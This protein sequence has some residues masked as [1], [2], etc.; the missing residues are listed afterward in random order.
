MKVL[1]TGAAGF[2]GSHLVPE[3]VLAGHEVRAMVR[4]TS[5]D[6]GHG[7]EVVRADLLDK[8]SLGGALEGIEV[9][10][11]LVHSMTTSKEFEDTDRRAAHI[12]AAAARRHGVRRIIYLGGLGDDDDLSPHLASRSEV[13]QILGS[14]GIPVTTLRAALIIGSGGASFEMLRHLVERLPVMITPR[15]VETE[16]QPIALADVIRYLVLAL[17][18]D[19]TTGRILD[20]GGPEVMTYRDMMKRF[21]E[22]EGKRRWIL[23]VPVLTPRLSSYWV[24]LITP[25]PASVARPLIDGLRN[26]MVVTND[27][28]AELMPFE[29]TRFATSVMDALVDSLNS[30]LENARVLG[31]TPEVAGDAYRLG[32]GRRGPGK[33]LEARCL[34]VNAPPEDVWDAVESI[35]GENGWYFMDWAWTVRG[36]LDGLLGGPGNRRHRPEHVVP[37][38][39]L[40]AWT[41]ERCKAGS[42]LVLRSRM[43]LPRFARLGLHVRPHSKGA[44]LVQWVEFHP[45]L[46]TWLYWWAAFPLHRVIF[47]GMMTAIAQKARRAKEAV[48]VRA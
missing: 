14:T 36:W 37:G 44:V 33:V 41:V 38:D 39:D 22:V 20:I 42:D 26:K 21:A 19:G 13:G 2:I 40:D 47:R 29:L 25:V 4:R 48:L 3:L 45:T 30:R 17:G 24:N 12:L 43:R 9:V 32:H 35:G 1:V 16:S 15:W 27:E 18:N 31:A 10:Y 5:V 7:V 23:R 46:L 6:F 8:G 28:A 34:L 11:Y